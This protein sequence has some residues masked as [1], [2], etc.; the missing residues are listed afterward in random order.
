[1]APFG[2]LLRSFPSPKIGVGG[3]LHDDHVFRVRMRLVV[4]PEHGGPLKPGKLAALLIDPVQPLLVFLFFA[5]LDMRPD[6]GGDRPSGIPVLH[7]RE[8]RHGYTSDQYP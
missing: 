7:R 5:W 4:G 2:Q 8:F 3:E 1:M 6:D